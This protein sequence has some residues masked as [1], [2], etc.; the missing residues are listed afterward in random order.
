[1]ADAFDAMISSRPYRPP[2]PVPDSLAEIDRCSGTQFDPIVAGIFIEL[3][4]AQ[5]SRLVA[6]G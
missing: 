6:A 1:V 3:C 4:R 2:L 5:V